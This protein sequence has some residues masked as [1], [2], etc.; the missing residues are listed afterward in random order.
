MSCTAVATIPLPRL[1][2]YLNDRLAS[3]IPRMLK[4][5]VA[6]QRRRSPQ[7]Q[8]SGMERLTELRFVSNQTDVDTPL[9]FVRRR[10]ALGAVAA[11][12]GAKRQVETKLEFVD[13]IRV[14]KQVSPTTRVVFIFF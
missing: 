10:R 9:R 5:K 6:Q 13:R 4:E 7:G 1:E 12:D 11:G 2:A 14:G 8:A 3:N